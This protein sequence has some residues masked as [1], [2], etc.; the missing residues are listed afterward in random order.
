MNSWLTYLD[1]AEFYVNLVFKPICGIAVIKE[2]RSTKECVFPIEDIAPNNW[3]FIINVEEQ[4]FHSLT[5]NLINIK[6]NLFVIL[7]SESKCFFRTFLK[8]QE[9]ISICGIQIH[10]LIRWFPKGEIKPV[11]YSVCLKSTVGENKN[12]VYCEWK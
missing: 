12:K 8:T 10:F 3:C 7:F 1:N 11:K 6:Y 5:I 2:I 4:C 9:I